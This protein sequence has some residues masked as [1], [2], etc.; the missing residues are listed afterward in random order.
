MKEIEVV[1]VDMFHTL[2]DSVVS[3]LGQLGEKM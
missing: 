1:H 2:A 3:S